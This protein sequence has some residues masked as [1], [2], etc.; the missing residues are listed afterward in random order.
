M[1]LNIAGREEARGIEVAAAIRPTP[2]WK[3]WGN[4]AYVEAQY[5][6]YVFVSGSF[7]GKALPNVP[8]VV[9]NAGASYRFDTLWPV[10]L[11]V[12]GRHVGARFNTDANTVIMN[13][14]TVAD[15]YAFVD[16]PRSLFQSLEQVRL[17]FRV[18]NVTDKRYAIW[19]DP[20]RTGR[21]I[22]PRGASPDRHPRRWCLG[23]LATGAN[24]GWSEGSRDQADVARNGLHP[25]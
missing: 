3:F 10:E 22:T 15:A 12:S 4:F 16:L 17:T 6:D 18:R 13:A 2:A 1:T 11:G 7:S 24:R 14:Y 21:W 20:F 25:K 23:G 8:Q 19:G 9:A 5:R